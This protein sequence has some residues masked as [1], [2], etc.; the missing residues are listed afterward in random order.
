[1]GLFGRKTESAE[2]KAFREEFEKVTALIRLADELQQIAVGHAVN[3]AHSAFAQRFPSVQAFLARPRA[4]Q[5][6]Y[7]AGLT[8]AEERLNT[9]DF[10]GGLGFGLFKMWL[11]AAMAGDAPLVQS[12][13]RELERLSRKAPG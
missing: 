2:R 4:E 1:M 3:L 9:T 10:H 7:I 5:D 11:G 6:A 8:K 13:S 12:F